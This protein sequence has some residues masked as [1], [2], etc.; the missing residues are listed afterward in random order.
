MILI[1]H[2]NISTIAAQYAD[3][4]FK[5]FQDKKNIITQIL[6]ILLSTGK[7]DRNIH[8]NKG[9]PALKLIL[10]QAKLQIPKGKTENDRTDILYYNIDM[11]RIR[12]DKRSKCNRKNRYNFIESQLKIIFNSNSLKKLFSAEI[13]QLKI[14]NQLFTDGGKLDSRVYAHFFDYEKYYKT[15][16][17][18]IGK[19]LGIIC[20]PYCNRNYITYVSSEDERRIIGPTYDHFFNKGTYKFCALSF[21]NLIPS[22]YVCNSNLKNRIN[23]DLKY[24]LYPYRDEFGKKAFFDFDLKLVSTSAEKRIIFRPTIELVADI[25]EDDKMKLVG[26]D[27]DIKGQVTGSIKVFKLREIYETHYDTV[28]EVHEKF[29]ANSPYYIESIKEKLTL[30]GVGEDEFYRFHF[31]N[32]YDNS[33]FHRRPLAQLS[34]DIY[35]KMKQIQTDTLT[36]I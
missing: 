19:E 36:G 1:N 34:K 18:Y 12:V 13:D 15:I 10:N 22:C 6:E 33:D 3:D 25:S 28:E 24:H 29:D 2:S 32:Y 20:C 30:L 9:L 26:K 11:Y 7:Y 31:R 8:V 17:K 5:Q 16:N 14:L 35:T 27:K 4:L 21:F 23:F